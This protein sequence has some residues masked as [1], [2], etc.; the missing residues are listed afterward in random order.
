VGCTVREP[1][2]GFEKGAFGDEDGQKVCHPEL[3]AL[4]RQVHRLLTRLRR[5]LQQITTRLLTGEIDQGIF[6]L[7]E[8]EQDTLFVLD[9]GH[10]G[11]GIGASDARQDRSQIEARPKDA[12][13]DGER[14]TAAL[15]EVRE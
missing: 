8:G 1:I 15:A 7:F 6:R 12:G 9:E 4:G 14:V 3:I 11:T 2:L 5:G 13:T 10:L